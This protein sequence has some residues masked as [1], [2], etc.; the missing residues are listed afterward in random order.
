MN[1]TLLS[2]IDYGVI[3]LYNAVLILVGM[4]LAKRKVKSASD[5]TTA[6]QSLSTLTV[7]GSIISTCMGASVLFSNYQLIHNTGLRGA[8]TSAF[9]YAGW[10]ILILLVGK[11]RRTGASSIP[12]YISMR[13][14][15][16]AQK[17][18]AWSIVIVGLSTCAA[19]F[20]SAGATMESLGICGPTLGI[21][22]G[23]AI[24]VL[25]TFF[26][27]LWGSAVTNSIQSIFILITV[28]II[29]PLVAANAAGGFSTAMANIPPEKL[30]FSG[31]SMSMMLFFSY[32][33]GSSLN[34]ACEPSYSKYS[35]AAKD[36]KAAV[37]GQL[38]AWAVC[39]A[40]AVISLIP[41]L[42]IGQIFP[43]MTDGSLFV[44]R[45]IATYLPVGVRGFIIAVVLS[46]L[47]TTGNSFL[48]LLTSSI[49]DDVI[50]PMK[51]DISDK[52]LLRISRLIIAGGAA[53][54]ATLAIVV[55]DIATAFKIGGNAFGP[56]V[57]IPVL[58]S[59]FW[60]GINKKA[61]SI[62]MVASVLTSIC[63]DIYFVYVA[64]EG[65]IGNMYACVV[66][67]VINIFGSLY[68][69]AKEKAA[70]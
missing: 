9:W 17:I 47:I 65:A 15:Q 22:I 25:F 21:I 10:L 69:N 61:V 18:S 67:L 50:R 58:L 20:K 32:M 54:I 66:S 23:A 46:L 2:G 14:G 16:K 24:I 43:D 63:M 12:D 64:G 19:Q 8:L 33:V 53:V 45:L 30:D 49:T 11:I 26:S 35:L 1:N 28:V 70:A 52:A 36:E 27:G 42:W 38:V 68:F 55:P 6:G 60:K 57:A 44:P 51:P 56:V 48:L 7:A 3:V 29:I 34:T 37:R 62:A 13:F 31:S 59:F 41:P 4:Y 5:F 40:I 39:T